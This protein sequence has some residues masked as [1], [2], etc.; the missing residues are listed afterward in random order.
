MP[1]KTIEEFIQTVIS[2]GLA[3]DR[4]VAYNKRWELSNQKLRRYGPSPERTALPLALLLAISS[5]AA[6]QVRRS[7]RSHGS[8][9]PLLSPG[10]LPKRCWDR[11]MSLSILSFLVLMPLL[12][13]FSDEVIASEY[14]WLPTSL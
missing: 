2:R 7:E 8:Y 14:R 6:E 12:L 1:A 4:R 9:Y 5:A 3:E 13:G 11:F 10:T